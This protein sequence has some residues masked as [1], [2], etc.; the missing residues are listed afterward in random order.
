MKRV[1]MIHA[2]DHSLQRT[3]PHQLSSQ[4]V[5]PSLSADHDTCNGCTSKSFSFSL[6]IIQCDESGLLVVR[7]KWA[8]EWAWASSEAVQQS[9]GRGP[10]NTVLTGI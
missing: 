5:L 9:V 3:T 1:F 8:L 4:L 6:H 7:R 10:Q 2:R